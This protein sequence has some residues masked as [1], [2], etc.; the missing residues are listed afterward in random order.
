MTGSRKAVIF[1]IALFA[2]GGIAAGTLIAIR[3]HRRIRPITIS[4]AVFKQDHDPLKRYPIADVEVKSPDG[5]LLREGK[6]DFSGSFRVSFLTSVKLG[7]TIQ[8]SFRHPDFQP[9]D[10]EQVLSDKL[11]VVALTPLHGEAEPKITAN[12]G[13]VGNV[14]VRYST[15]ATKTENIGSAVKI[16]QIENQGN[17]P[18][19]EQLPCSPDG[20]WKATVGSAFL[21][22]GEGIVFRD[23]RVTCIAGPCPFTRIDTD[24]FSKGGR[25]I[26]VTA[27]TWSDTT[28]FLLQAEVFRTQLDSIVRISYPVIFG[29]AL[30]FTLPASAEGPSILAEM[31]GIPIVYPLAPSPGLSWAD[32]Q[33]KVEKNQA[34]DYR[35][36]L[37]DGY[38]FR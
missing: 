22:A 20:K 36:E 14:M 4:G 3:K 26:K 25:T 30:N 28:T 17:V 12:L 1:A 10:V 16:F 18:C 31:D 19:L 13:V 29:R 24:E 8:L 6:S 35:C 37:K 27:R 21:D 15:E 34:K 5:L 11:N 9:L 33:V 2:V 7:Q 38:R 32:C 23:A